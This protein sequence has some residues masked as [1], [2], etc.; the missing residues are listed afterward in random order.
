LNLTIFYN[1]ELATALHQKLVFLDRIIVEYRG[2]INQI[3]LYHVPT[4]MVKSYLMLFDTISLFVYDLHP[5]NKNWNKVIKSKF[6]R[7]F[8]KPDLKKLVRSGKSLK[9]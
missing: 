8:S 3:L 4:V 1:K 2:R 7:L 9:R 6:P 5:T